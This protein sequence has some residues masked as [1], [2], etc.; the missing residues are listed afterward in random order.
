MFGQCL[1]LGTGIS[2]ASTGVYVAFTS[3]KYNNEDRPPIRPPPIL[4]LI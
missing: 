1:L 4:R 3:D 2:M